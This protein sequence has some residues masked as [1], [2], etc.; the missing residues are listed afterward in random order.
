MFIVSAFV[1]YY[2]QRGGENTSSLCI[3]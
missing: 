2:K 3:W 1:K